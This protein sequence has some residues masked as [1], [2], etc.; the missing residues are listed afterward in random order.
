MKKILKNNLALFSITPS[1]EV[2][3]LYLFIF[4]IFWLSILFYF[5]FFFLFHLFL[6]FPKYF[7]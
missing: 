4:I 6:F 7:Y 2:H 1:V 3:S 5:F